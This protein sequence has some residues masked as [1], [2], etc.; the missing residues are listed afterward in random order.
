MTMVMPVVC[1]PRNHLKE[2]ITHIVRV[3]QA[4]SAYEG[5]II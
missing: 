5:E 1:V 3:C 2:Q 4:G